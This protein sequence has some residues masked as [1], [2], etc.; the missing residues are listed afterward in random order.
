MSQPPRLGHRALVDF[1]RVAYMTCCIPVRD[2]PGVE[3]RGV[4]GISR[5]VLNGQQ[6]A[7][8]IHMP[9]PTW[10]VMFCKGK[11]IPYRK[12]GRV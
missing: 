6:T 7:Y 3:L 4:S 1:V 10:R 11:N 2:V 9:E 12:F 8:G 5:V